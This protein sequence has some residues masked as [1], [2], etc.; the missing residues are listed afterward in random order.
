MQ[1]CPPCAADQP[2]AGQRQQGIDRRT[3]ATLAVAQEACRQSQAD[4]DCEAE[5][6]GSEVGVF[7]FA[8]EEGEERQR[9]G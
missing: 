5:E 3:G 2:Q 9:R 4:A 1:R 6:V 7:S 8:A